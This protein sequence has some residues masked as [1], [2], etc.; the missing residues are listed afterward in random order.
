MKFMR[1]TLHDAPEG[2]EEWALVNIESIQMIVIK[3]HINDVPAPTTLVLTGKEVRV[4]E[5][6]EVIWQRLKQ[7]NGLEEG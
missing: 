7:L 6:I 5:T 3:R 2:R 1:V 4:T